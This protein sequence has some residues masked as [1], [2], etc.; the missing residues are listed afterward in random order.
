MIRQR[1]RVKRGELELR[2]R[3]RQAAN[4]ERADADIRARQADEAGR[5]ARI[6]EQE[7]R[8]QHAEAQLGREKAALHERGMADD[9][10]IAESERERFAGTSADSRSNWDRGGPGE[11][12]Q[13]TRTNAYQPGRHAREGDERLPE[14]DV[15][16]RG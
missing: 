4:A 8:R 10:L 15:S 13:A 2:Q 16:R 14:Q 12:S 1:A 6:A 11:P 5:R 9:E 7:A 3:R